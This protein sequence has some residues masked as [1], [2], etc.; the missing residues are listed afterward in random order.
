MNLIKDLET[1]DMERNPVVVPKGTEFSVLPDEHRDWNLA[2]SGFLE[3]TYHDGTGNVRVVLDEEEVKEH[4]D[5]P[6]EVLDFFIHS[7][8]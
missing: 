2:L 5:R 1:T 4:F 6:E 7:G 3:L 8:N